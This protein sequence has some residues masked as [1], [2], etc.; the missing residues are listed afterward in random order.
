MKVMVF[1]KATADTEA[2][3]PPK[4]GEMEAMGS[5]IEA[6]VAAGIIK[7]PIFGGLKPSSFG[8]RVRFTGKDRTVIDG[9]FPETKEIVAGFSM[10]DVE[11]IEQAVE[12]VKKTPMTKD[13]E[14][15]I[16]PLY[17]MEELAAWDEGQPAEAPASA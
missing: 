8:K 10:W 11:S 2:G 7:E 16:R 14:I 12:W 3:V 15:E 4:P 13:C 5:Y 9:P 17:S 1:G 6:L